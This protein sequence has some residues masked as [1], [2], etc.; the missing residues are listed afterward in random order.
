[1]PVR[2]INS[3]PVIKKYQAAARR[4]RDP[5][6]LNRDIAVKLH[7]N[8][9]TRFVLEKSP[10]GAAWKPSQ[11]ALRQG[12]QTLTDTGRLRSSIRFGFG[13]TH[14][15]VFTNTLVYAFPHNEGIP[16]QPKRQ[17]IGFGPEDQKAIVSISEKYIR[18]S[19]R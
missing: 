3:G 1:M 18:D 10:T 16:P 2:I 6:P 17:F 8:V 13:K 12:G 14:A 5:S 4:L 15:E 7:Q 9:I 11:R 19:F